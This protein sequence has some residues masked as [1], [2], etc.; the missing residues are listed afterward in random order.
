M[1]SDEDE[2]LYG[3]EETLSRLRERDRSVQTRVWQLEHP[4]LTRVARSVAAGLD[5]EAVI[6]EVFTDFFFRH[7]D[8]L[9]SS[10]SIPAY[11]RIMTL[12]R[13]QREAELA[14]RQAELPASEGDP[15]TGVDDSLLQSSSSRW[16][17][18][19][20]LRLTPRAR[21]IFKLHYGH[22]LT[23]SEIGERVETS[24]QA[25]GKTILKGLELLRECLRRRE[26][27]Q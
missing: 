7:V 9:K 24:K 19:C 17:R 23:Y 11:L 25:V 27:A 8:V 2:A 4:R 3:R 15:E 5:V 10:R 14:S 16:L 6:A 13:V 18:D 1:W 22:E 20:Y 12:R 21:E 26:R